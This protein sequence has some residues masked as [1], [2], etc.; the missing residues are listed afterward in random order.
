VV[1]NK[2]KSKKKISQND[3]IKIDARGLSKKF[4]QQL[5]EAKEK[6]DL[7]EFENQSDDGLIAVVLTGRR[8][9]KSLSI[10]DSLL[11]NKK[12]LLEG[13]IIS[14]VNEVLDAIRE[15]NV[16]LSADVSKSLYESVKAY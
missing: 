14:V 13:M 7:L 11:D 12:D 15:A 4:S 6:F 10:A 3:Q 9:I 2:V 16:K 8:E 1:K 5:T